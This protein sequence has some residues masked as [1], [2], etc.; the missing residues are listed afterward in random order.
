[1]RAA[2]SNKYLT[3]KTAGDSLFELRSLRNALDL[4]R[5]TKMPSITKID[6]KAL[7]RLRWMF[8]KPLAF[9]ILVFSAAFTVL[10]QSDR[11]GVIKGDVVDSSGAAVPNVTLTLFCDC[12]ECP[13]RSCDGCCLLSGSRNATTDAEGRFEFS[14]IPSGVY[15]V[16]G[17]ASGFSTIKAN[18]VHVEMGQTSNVRLTFSLGQGFDV[19]IKSFDEEPGMFPVR[20]KIVNANAEDAAV[21][22][23]VIVRQLCE[24]SECPD[25]PCSGDCIVVASG[26]SDQTGY[27]QIHLRAGDYTVETTAGRYSKV[28]PVRVKG[29]KSL[30]IKMAMQQ[31]TPRTN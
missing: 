1:M 22:A 21:E 8:L 2:L 11:A 27:S 23:K 25:K 9:S 5:S 17:E 24:H 29:R 3:A 4:L 12:S 16:R 30:K 18:G 19:D 28:S 26:T 13:N 7:I 20:I 6:L 15:S 31:T 14:N 10:A